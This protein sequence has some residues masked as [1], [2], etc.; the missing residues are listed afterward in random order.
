M[1]GDIAAAGAGAAALQKIVRQE[2]DVSANPV[3]A[4]SLHR[5]RHIRRKSQL[6][7]GIGRR[8]R[9]GRQAARHSDGG[10]DPSR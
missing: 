5:R 10:H 2:P 7:G 4:D 8:P 6:G 3:R 1:G 9:G